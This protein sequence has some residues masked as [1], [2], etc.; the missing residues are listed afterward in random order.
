MMANNTRPDCL[1][2]RHRPEASLPRWLAASRVAAIVGNRA[3]V[4]GAQ[5]H[6]ARDF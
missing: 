4:M 6:S 3:L 2:S 1:R 5:S